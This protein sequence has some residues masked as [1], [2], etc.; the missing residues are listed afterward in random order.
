MLQKDSIVLPTFNSPPIDHNQ[1]NKLNRLAI[2]MAVL[3]RLRYVEEM[4]VSRI[5][6]ILW[7]YTFIIPG[8]LM[9]GGW[10]LKIVVKVS[11]IGKISSKT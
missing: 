7:Y 6:R 10:S 2:L 4:G 1:S 9:G 11:L 8:N 3:L 5:S